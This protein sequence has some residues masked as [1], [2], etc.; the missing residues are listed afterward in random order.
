MGAVTGGGVYTHGDTAMLEAF[1]NA[2]FRFLQWNDGNADN[3]RSVVVVSD[4]TFTAFFEAIPME[5]YTITVLS[6]DEI[7]GTV[8]GGGT[9]QTGE[10]T[11]IAAI[12]HDGYNFEHWNDGNQENPRTITVT[13]DA[14][15]VAYFARRDGI[16]EV[17]D[18][19]MLVYSEGRKVHVF[20]IGETGEPVYLFDMMG[21]CL[22]A[23]TT[24][25]QGCVLEVPQPGIYLVKIGTHPAIKTP[26]L[27]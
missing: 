17:A 23:S 6:D 22:A 10:E 20:G 5:T 19:E 15:Y 26:V 2:G 8:W 7:M 27:Q 25:A 9:F 3:P 16:S 1:P 13:A 24:Q 14:T 12:A 18:K 11:Q 4:Q 21:R